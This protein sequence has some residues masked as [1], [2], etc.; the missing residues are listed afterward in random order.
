MMSSVF[1]IRV[2][3]VLGFMCRFYKDPK[4]SEGLSCREIHIS[5]E[6]KGCGSLDFFFTY[7][8]LCV[9]GFVV[10]VFSALKKPTYLKV[11]LK[12]S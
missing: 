10:T 4:M 2:D 11:C 7:L 5:A 3:D 1:F 12:A 9:F 6:G 8:D